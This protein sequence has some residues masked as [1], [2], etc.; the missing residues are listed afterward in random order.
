[1]M[2]Y[3]HSDT[4]HSIQEEIVRTNS[5]RCFRDLSTLE[6]QYVERTSKYSPAHSSLL[7][8]VRDIGQGILFERTPHSSLLEGS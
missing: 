4:Y 1:M 2:T 7:S 5:T 6:F 8:K 3:T